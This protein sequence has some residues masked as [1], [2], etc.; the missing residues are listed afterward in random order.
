[1]HKST[2]SFLQRKT[3]GEKVRSDPNYSIASVFFSSLLFFKLVQGYVCSP[4]S[5]E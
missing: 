2:T 1:V 5:P 3:R 4:A